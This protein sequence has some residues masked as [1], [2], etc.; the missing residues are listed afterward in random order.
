MDLDNLK[1]YV[2]EANNSNKSV[3]ERKDAALKAC[4]LALP[5]VE[6]LNK[7]GPMAKMLLK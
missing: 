6:K 3:E 1:Q 5:L 2:L 4:E 7:L